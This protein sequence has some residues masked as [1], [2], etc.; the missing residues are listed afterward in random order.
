MKDAQLAKIFKALSNEQRLRIFRMLCEWQAKSATGQIE[1]PCAG[2]ER[3]FTR[4]C[5]SIALSPSTVSHHFKELQN[6]GLITTSRNGQT[7]LCTVNADALAAIAEFAQ[8]VL[9]S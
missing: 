8:S 5:C 9:K 2:V 6:A 4:T 1:D 3:C 7:F